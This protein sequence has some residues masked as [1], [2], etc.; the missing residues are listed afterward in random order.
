MCFYLGNL[1]KIIKNVVKGSLAA[2]MLFF[3]KAT[4]VSSSFFK[5]A[6][7]P[8]PPSK[9]ARLIIITI[10]IQYPG[11]FLHASREL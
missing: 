7:A 2:F 3:L 9:R 5:T 1:R 10:I 11:N 4:D 8:S 6:C